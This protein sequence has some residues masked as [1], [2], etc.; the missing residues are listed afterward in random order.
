MLV[1][2]KINILHELMR[3]DHSVL[4]T[5]IIPGKIL[6]KGLFELLSGIEENILH[7]FYEQEAHERLEYA[8]HI[9]GREKEINFWEIF[10]WKKKSLPESGKELRL[11]EEILQELVEKN[12]IG[13]EVDQKKIGIYESPELLARYEDFHFGENEHFGIKNFPHRCAELVIAEARKRNIKGRVLELGCALGRSTLDFA[14]YF[15]EAI[16]LDFS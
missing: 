15:D 5:M 16:G 7:V 2:P 13:E 10:V 14:E 6:H 12:I 1:H 11:I 4:I 9:T 8:R 3:L